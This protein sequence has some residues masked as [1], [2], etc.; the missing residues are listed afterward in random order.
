MRSYNPAGVVAV[1]RVIVKSE[2]GND[3]FKRFPCWAVT[4]SKLQFN[5]HYLNG[6]ICSNF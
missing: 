4:L 2:P 1:E 5:N 6:E 3:S